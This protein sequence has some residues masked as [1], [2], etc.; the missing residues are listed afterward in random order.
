MKDFVFAKAAW[1]SLGFDWIQIIHQVKMKVRR[2]GVAGMADIREVLPDGNLFSGS[3]FDR[4]RLGVGEEGKPLGD[5]HD[6][7]VARQR[8][9]VFYLIGVKRQAIL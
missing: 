5:L 9:K 7:I 1:D 3:Y 4:P 6:D 2:S 8:P